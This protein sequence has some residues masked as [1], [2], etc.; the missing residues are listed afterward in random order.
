MGFG[1]FCVF[2]YYTGVKPS[3]GK[4]GTYQVSE[5]RVAFGKAVPEDEIDVEAGFLMVP[6]ARPRPVTHAPSV[7]QRGEEPQSPPNPG[8]GPQALPP[9]VTPPVVGSG[10]GPRKKLAIQFSANRD[11]LFE[12]WQAIANLADMAGAVSI[13]IEAN[14]EAGF[15][16]NKL[17]NAVFEPL[18][19]ADLI[20]EL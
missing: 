13:R 3:L 10:Q 18:E 11:K 20:D 16:E 5:A 9:D 8:I 4:D 2:S 12:S 1:A 19:E 17:R 7:G 6:E 14:S 15:D